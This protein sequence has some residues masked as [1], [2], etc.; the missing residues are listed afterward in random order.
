MT[1]RRTTSRSKK[2][3]SR[4]FFAIN[5]RMLAL[6][7]FIA[8]LI[9]SLL[10]GLWALYLDKIVREKFEGKKWA[11]PARV[12]SRPLELYEG[13]PL[14]PGLFEQELDALGY[15]MV[16]SVA[17]A[18]QM[19]RRAASSQEVSYE[20]YSRGFNFWDKRE[21]PQRFTLRID[22]G[23]VASL[24]DG[25]GAAIPLV[26][27]EPEEIGGIYP[28]NVED[29]L[30][31]KLDGLPPLLGETLLAVED[32]HFL[33]HHGVSPLA[34][35]RAMLVNIREGDVVQG[36]STLSQQ[37]VKNFYLTQKQ[38]LSR[39]IPEA[40]MSLLLELHYSKSQ[41]L[42]TYI[43]EVYMGQSGSREIH[44]F[45][46]ASQH[47]FR[48]PLA[49]ISTQEVALLVGLVKGPSYY[50]PWRQPERAKTRRNLVL[51][52][53]RDEGLIDEKQ[54]KLAQAAP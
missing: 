9:A 17:T 8:A 18:G 27:M 20:V 47:Y 3:S 49:E 5:W 53:M 39:K 15:R 12:Y 11:L 2:S 35:F 44:G 31:V 45:A 1:K 14:T 50:N 48:Q 16:P 36:G 21:D 37:L 38:S 41:I 32:K 6:V 25:K 40:I 7:F 52:V 22:E 51:S 24:V 54:L 13:L 4:R 19:Q 26:R 42:E 46:L 33:E 10:L 29:R 23:K 28:N 34:I 30:L 43:N